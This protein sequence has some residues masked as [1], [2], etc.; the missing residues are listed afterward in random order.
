MRASSTLRSWRPMRGIAA[1]ARDEKGTTAVEFGLIAAPFLMLLFGIMSVGFY[2]FVVFSL[3]NAV[4][5]ASRVLRTGQA[6]TQKPNPMTPEEFKTRI[7]NNLPAFMSC[8]GANSKIRVNVQNFNGYGS[9]TSTSCLESG[10]LI[11]EAPADYNPGG[12]SV[13]VLV[14]VCFEWSLSQ[15]MAGMAYWIMPPGT[16]MANGSTLIR[17][18]TTFTT[19]PYN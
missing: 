16:S 15:V 8:S 3:E 18:S 10:A 9:I 4:E 6:Q 5:T 19:E 2:F 1:I 14:T 13:V 7:C 17:A 12:S 11:P